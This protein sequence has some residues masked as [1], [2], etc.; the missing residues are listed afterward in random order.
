MKPTD[1]G[2]APH[3]PEIRTRLWWLLVTGVTVGCVAGVLAIEIHQAFIVLFFAVPIV[4]GL[5]ARSVR[6]PRCGVPA[7]WRGRYWG[8]FTPPRACAKCGLSFTPKD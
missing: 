2:P 3:A 4:F 7:I 8:G 6:C 1:S 5:A